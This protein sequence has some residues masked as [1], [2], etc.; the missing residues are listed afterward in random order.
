[1]EDGDKPATEDVN[2]KHDDIKKKA[3]MMASKKRRQLGK[4]NILQ[5]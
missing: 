5:E 3:A 1:M 4:Q 2:K